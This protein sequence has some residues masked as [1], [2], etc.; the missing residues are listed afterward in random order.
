MSSSPDVDAPDDTPDTAIPQR[1][2][3]EQRS[4]DSD[5]RKSTRSNKSY[6]TEVQKALV[7]GE[8]IVKDDELDSIDMFTIDE[9]DSSE[10]RAKWL[11]AI[12]S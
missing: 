5:L 7:S 3:Q 10:A 9:V 1:R 11:E 2:A 4:W 12:D 6:V 8:F